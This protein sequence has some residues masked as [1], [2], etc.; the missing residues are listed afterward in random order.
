MLSLKQTLLKYVHTYIHSLTKVCSCWLFCCTNTCTPGVTAKSD[1]TPTDYDAASFRIFFFGSA[2]D[3]KLR[4]KLAGRDMS[5]LKVLRFWSPHVCAVTQLRPESNLH[6]FKTTVKV[7]MYISPATKLSCMYLGTSCFSCRYSLSNFGLCVW[8][9]FSRGC[10]RG[11]WEDSIKHDAQASTFCCPFLQLIDV[12]AYAPMNVCILVH[13][14]FIQ[15]EKWN[16]YVGFSLA[17]S[18]P[19]TPSQRLMVKNEHTLHKIAHEM[20]YVRINNTGF[21]FKL[22]WLTAL[23]PAVFYYVNNSCQIKQISSFQFLLA[24]FW[25]AR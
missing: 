9:T 22:S 2:V 17:A 3:L 11:N 19:S 21:R 18:F 25:F 23:G 14:C 1:S 6:I 7:D 10:P 12:P 24:Q 16:W 20:S 13:A 8:C 15:A 5:E 4:S